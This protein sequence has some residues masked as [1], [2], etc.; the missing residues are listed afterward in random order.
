LIKIINNKF[1]YAIINTQYQLQNYFKDVEYI[2]IENIKIYY[3]NLLLQLDETQWCKIFEYIIIHQ[4]SMYNTMI[5][6]TTHDSYTLTD[7]PTLYLTHD[8][9]NIAKYCIQ[10]SNIPDEDIN[11]LISI[12]NNNNIIN[13]NIYTITKIINE[14]FD[15]MKKENKEYKELK[16][17]IRL[18]ESQI[19]PILIDEQYIPNFAKHITK[20]AN[21]RIIINKPFKSNISEDIIKKIM[22]TNV[23][24]YWKLLLIMGIGVFSNH[25]N[26]DYLEIMKYLAD[27]QKLFLIVASTDYIYGTNYQFCHLYIGKDL[28]NI[29]QEKLIQ[30]IGRVGRTFHQYDY[31]IRFRNNDCIEKIFNKEE[32]NLEQINFNNLFCF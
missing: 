24:N 23:E 12:I 31:S 22:L 11:N 1:N 7:G 27:N 4:T 13:D 16:Q 18:L 10:T 5:N 20:Y 30:S 17:S 29:T 28:N 9:D 14:K 32:N 26:K 8:V 19:K 25:K 15:D 2:T 6:L 21:N 3:L